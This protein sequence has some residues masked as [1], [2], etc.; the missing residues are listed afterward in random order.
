MRDGG[1]GRTA[2]DKQREKAVCKLVRVIIEKNGGDGGAAAVDGDGEKILASQLPD[3]QQW[4]AL[5]ESAAAMTPESTPSRKRKSSAKEQET[6]TA[7]E[8]VAGAM[9][10]APPVD[11]PA[12]P[13]SAPAP[14]PPAFP[15]LGQVPM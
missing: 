7:A 3:V 5:V 15:D 10:A 12:V 1:S 8:I 14:P 11:A 2:E 13:P 9:P 6:V 4:N